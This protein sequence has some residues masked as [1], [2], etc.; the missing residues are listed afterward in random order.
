M[1]EE[2]LCYATKTKF[3]ASEKRKAALALNKLTYAIRRAYH[4]KKR[5]YEAF[6]SDEAHLEMI[7]M[8]PIGQLSEDVQKS[9]HKELRFFREHNTSKIPR[10][11]T[12]SDLIRVFLTSSDPYISGIRLLPPKKSYV[13][14]K[15]VISLLKCP[16]VDVNSEN[17][18]TSE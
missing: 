9:R 4:M 16:N 11:S 15:D 13:L 10:Q 3:H 6:P 18:I 17:G 14:N 5:T 1:S 12:N 7:Y 2:E 8:L